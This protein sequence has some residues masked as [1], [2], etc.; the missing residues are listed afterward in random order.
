M[1]HVNALLYIEHT[2]SATLQCNFPISA[3][4][5]LPFFHWICGVANVPH[6]SAMFAASACASAA[7]T[8][9][10]KCHQWGNAAR[11]FGS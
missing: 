7:P 4:D 11:W 3:W 6:Q 5:D 10:Q 9:S 2:P 8:N 1:P